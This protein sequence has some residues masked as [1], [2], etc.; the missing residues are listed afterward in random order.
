MPR[1]AQQQP[2][3]GARRRKQPSGAG[4]DCG[5][6]PATR[7]GEQLQGDRRGRLI[8]AMMELC[9]DRG[10]TNFSVADVATTAGVSSKTF[11]QLFN[12]KEDCLL[13]AYRA[14]AESLLGEVRPVVRGTDMHRATRNVVLERLLHALQRRPQAGRLLLVEA[15]AGGAAVRRERERVLGLFERRAQEFLGSVSADSETLD[16]PATALVGA[17]RALV[18]RELR[19]HSEE[20]L[21]LLAGDLQEW[22]ESY[23]TPAGGAR[24]STGRQSTLPARA[25]RPPGADK[26]IAAPE[27]L[28]RGRHSLPAAVVARSHRDRILHGTAEVIADRGYAEATVSEI[29]SAARISREVFYEHFSS[30]QDAYLAA[31]QYATQQILETCTTAYFAGT[32]WPERVWNALSALIDLLVANPRL[33]QLRLVECYAAGPVAIEQSE[34]LVRAS[35]IFVQEGFNAPSA[36]DVPAIAAHAIAGYI[37]E[38]FYTHIS[39]GKL[40]ELPRLLPRLVYVATA[41]FLGPVASIA[42]VEAL[43]DRAIRGS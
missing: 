15:L 43:R 29:V 19:G 12:D 30:K 32:T 34:Q 39:R 37:F 42:A 1:T 36:K 2:A 6:T 20:N 31:Q 16:L 40:S 24:W 11:Y 13:A 26:T 17:V 4:T 23:A 9:A 3:S 5:V 33:A 10:Y 18:S 8:D 7:V 41:P 21:P 14:S 27:R 35:T 22:I 28:P 38:E 25:A